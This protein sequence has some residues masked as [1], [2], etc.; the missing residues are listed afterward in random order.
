[1]ISCPRVIRFEV[2]IVDWAIKL[3]EKIGEKELFSRKSLEAEERELEGLDEIDWQLY[4]IIKLNVVMKHI[5]KGQI[6]TLKVLRAI[7][8][9]VLEVEVDDEAGYARATHA[10][11]E[12]LETEDTAEELF[13]RRMGLRNYLKLLKMSRVS[14]RNAKVAKEDARR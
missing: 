6:K 8:D 12:G 11:V 14:V 13:R 4:T 9:K 2:L 5:Y 1:M 10:P 3:L 7:L